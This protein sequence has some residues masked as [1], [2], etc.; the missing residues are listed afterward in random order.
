LCWNPSSNGIVISV[1]EQSGAN[2][3]AFDSE[4][5]IFFVAVGGRLLQYGLNGRLMRT[6]DVGVHVTALG[7]VSLGFSFE[8]R[9]VLAGTRE[10]GVLLIGTDFRTRALTV[11]SEERLSDLPIRRLV[12]GHGDDRAVVDVFDTGLCGVCE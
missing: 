9:V 2:L 7:L 5:N 3:L 6:I 1:I 11:L 10:G 8:R 12:A 4:M